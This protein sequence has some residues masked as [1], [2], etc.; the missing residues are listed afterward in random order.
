VDEGVRPLGR[1]AELT[2]VEPTPVVFSVGEENDQRSKRGVRKHDRGKERVVDGSGALGAKAGEGVADRS[3]VRGGLRQPDD[4][5]GKGEERGLVGRSQPAE[6]GLPSGAER[7][8]AFSFHAAARVE[9]QNR[10]DRARLGGHELGPLRHPV[11]SQLEVAALQAGH[12]LA[13]PRHE[14]VDV[15]LLHPGPEHGRRGARL[16]TRGRNRGP[17][18]PEGRCKATP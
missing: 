17:P 9:N 11:V 6:K 14:G 15:D 7:G 1:G 2:R 13:A 16:R 5:L 8:E 10:Q 4:L 18:H 3:L 12:D